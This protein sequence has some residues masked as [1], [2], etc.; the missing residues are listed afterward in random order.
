MVIPRIY[1]RTRDEALDVDR[2]RILDAW[3]H[4]QDY[5]RLLCRGPQFFTF[6]CAAAGRGSPFLCR[7]RGRGLAEGSRACLNAGLL[8][9]SGVKVLEK[10][11][12]EIALRID[13]GGP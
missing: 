8:V 7:W 6:A 12:F 3:A 13:L 1:L 10:H 11:R 5:C 9:S 2:P 4:R